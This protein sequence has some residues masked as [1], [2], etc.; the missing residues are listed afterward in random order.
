MTKKELTK[1][2]KKLAQK[3]YDD[4]QALFE[5]D[6]MDYDLSESEVFQALMTAQFYVEDVANEE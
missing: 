6:G 3:F 4:A 2:A 5:D 1:K